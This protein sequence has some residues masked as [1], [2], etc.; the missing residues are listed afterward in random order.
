[1]SWVSHGKESCSSQAVKWWK[2]EP[3]FQHHWC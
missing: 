3:R 2:H 1:M